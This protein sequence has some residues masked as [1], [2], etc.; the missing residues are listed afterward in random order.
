MIV[1]HLII[2]RIFNEYT[3]VHSTPTLLLTL[4][5]GHRNTRHCRYNVLI[6]LAMSTS[7][8]MRG[9]KR[10]FPVYFII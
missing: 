8:T 4:L 9:E 7:L 2:K 10:Q 5:L 6:I 3:V 1:D